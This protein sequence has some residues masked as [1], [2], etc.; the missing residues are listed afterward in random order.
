[1]L[2][3]LVHP[4]MSVV[5]REAVMEAREARQLL[6][7]YLDQDAD[8]RAGIGT[9]LNR[10]EI[11]LAEVGRSVTTRATTYPAVSQVAAEKD[12]CGTKVAASASGTGRSGREYSGP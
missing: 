9:P 4:D 1:M 2:F 6:D 8:L 3:G 5:Q 11:S 10:G 7:D 12:A